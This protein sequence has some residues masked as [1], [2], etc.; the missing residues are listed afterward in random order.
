MILATEEIRYQTVRV[1][2]A[3]K[4]EKVCFDQFWELQMSINLPTILNSY[5]FVFLCSELI[6]LSYSYVD[7][8]Q[9]LLTVHDNYLH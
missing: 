9:S 2:I 1:K 3:K 5:Q 7:W 4:I 6:Y 8:K